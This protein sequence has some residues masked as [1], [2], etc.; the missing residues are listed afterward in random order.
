[1]FSISAVNINSPI[2]GNAT[3]YC[4]NITFNTTGN[5]TTRYFF[6]NQTIPAPNCNASVTNYG[7]RTFSNITT[8]KSNMISATIDMNNPDN[9]TALL[10]SNYTMI[11]A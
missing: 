1:M 11:N 5:S 6:T 10:Q 8:N 2:Q 7:V 4:P 9:T 3:V